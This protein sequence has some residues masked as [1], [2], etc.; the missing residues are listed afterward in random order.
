MHIILINK[1][2]IYHLCYSVTMQAI[3]N[4]KMVLFALYSFLLL[5]TTEREARILINKIGNKIY[6][7]YSIL[8]LCEYFNKCIAIKMRSVL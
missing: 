3:K 8:N 5:G 1:L 7:F 6:E 2:I 4:R